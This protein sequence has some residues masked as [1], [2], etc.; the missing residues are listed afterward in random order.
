MTQPGVLRIFTNMKRELLVVA[1][2]SFAVNLLMLAPSL[3]M[4]QVYDRVLISQNFLTLVGSTVIL[5]FLLAIVAFSE[6]GRSRLL[7]RIGI[8]MDQQ[9]N[10]SLF[11]SSFQ[12]QLDRPQPNPSQPLSDLTNIRQFLTGNGIFAFFDLP[13]LPIY[14]GVLYL[15]HPLLGYLGVLFAVI[16]A[17]IVWISH[18]L[19]TRPMKCALTS[20]VEVNNGQLAQFRNAE[21]IETLGMFGQLKEQWWQQYHAQALQQ[22]VVERLG[23]HMGAI[24]KFMRFSKQSISLG[25]GAW[26]VIHGELTVGAMIAG[27]ILMTRALQPIDMIVN[28]WKGFVTARTAHQRLLDLFQNYTVETIEAREEVGPLQGEVELRNLVA[29]VPNRE[30]PILQE[31]NLHIDAG[32]ILVVVGPSGSGKTTLARTL[33]GLWPHQQGEVLLDGRNISEWDRESLGAQL[34]YLPQDVELMNGSIAQN[35]ARF[36]EVDS[37]QVIAASQLAGVHEMVLRFPKG[38]DT[39]VGEEG[40]ILSAGQ[41]Q[42]IALARALYGS[43]AIIV[44]DEPNANLDEFGEAALV[45]AIRQLKQQQK[46]V[47]LVTH[48]K[49]IV[50]VADQLVTM[51]EGQIQSVQL[52]QA[53]K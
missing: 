33:L 24:S 29:T 47:L 23:R 5:I 7:V 15:L 22:G 34:G 49:N 8:R 16:M 25:A 13:W 12:A 3:Y 21:S 1:L 6:W 27:N 53:G 30:Q 38:Y 43:P 36:G 10:Q 40:G 28:A 46:T 17:I 50:A 20:W 26:L 18:M 9:I 4:L 11:H 35:I 39:S 19:T 52:L 14:L 2:F 44:L 48:R 37:E 51:K 41:R 32:T 31:I 42:R 45:E